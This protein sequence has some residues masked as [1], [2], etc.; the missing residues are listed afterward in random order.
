MKTHPPCELVTWGQVCR[1]CRE[2]AQ[3]IRAAGF[4]PDMIVAI[5]RGGY[6]PSRILADQLGLME[7]AGIRIE[8]YH[9]AHKGAVA[10]VRQPLAMDLSG[11]RILLVDDVSDTGDT[12]DVAL[13]HL[14]GLGP[15][16]QIR[17]A[18][19]HH[20]IVSRIEPDFFARKI[21]KWRWII[22]PWAV[23]EDLASFAGEMEPV[24]T[25]PESLGRQLRDERGIRVRR[26]VLE[27]VLGLIS[28]Q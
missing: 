25:D 10:R 1:L 24:P 20:K 16:E 26:S 19:I 22:Y 3:K 17:T 15:A 5:G 4:K 12:F 21:V 23:L 6:V 13:A 7:L 27:D 14:R 18:A 11:R 9:G 28:I 8:H 2:L